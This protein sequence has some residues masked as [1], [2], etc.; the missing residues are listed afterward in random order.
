MLPMSPPAE[1]MESHSY[2]RR[3]SMFVSCLALALVCGVEAQPL[4]SISTEDSLFLRTVQ[5][6]AFEFFW[7]EANASNGLIRDRSTST[8]PSSIASV[9]FGISSLCVAADNGWL[10]RSA[11]ADRV[12][13]TLRTFWTG[14]QGYAASGMIGRLGFF[15]HFLKMDTAVRDWNCELSS[16][17]TGLLLAGV[18]HAQQ[19]FDGADAVETEIRALAD[20]IYRRANFEAFRNFGLWLN[21]GWFP[22]TGW[23]DA[24]WGKGNYSEAMI[25]YIMALGSPTHP[26]APEL[27]TNW[28]SDYDYGTHFGYTYVYYP[29]LFVHQYSHCWIDFRGITDAKMAGY[30]IDYFENSRRATLAQRAYCSANPAGHPGY[31]DS[32]WGITA[33]DGP[34]GIGYQARGAPPAQND[35]GTLAPTAPGGSIVFAPEECLKALKAMYAL[36]CV[37][38]ETRLWGPYGF[39]DAFNLRYN[40]FDLD[41]IGIDEGPIVLMIE[42]FFTQSVWRKFMQS[43]YIQTGLERAGFRPVTSVE[44]SSI[45]PRELWLEQ[46]YPNPFN[47]STTIRYTLPRSD[48]VELCVV[49]LMGRR[50]SLVEA[51]WKSPGAYEVTFEAGELS[52]GTYFAVLRVGAEQHV[53]A[54]VLL[55]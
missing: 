52:A 28:T 14:P 4:I 54:M 15:Y 6:K 41:Y 29:P 44:S 49:D 55:K 2:R 9:G 11:A 19:Y 23:L 1:A 18:L 39:R 25:L 10:A 35:D 30:G 53:R 13:T 50:V 46:N 32:V 42:N 21:M 7:N 37:G 24:W 34:P 38:S 47:P 12:R 3:R 43:P 31:S 26:V 20:S 8:S 45:R 22:E 36:Y 51:A 27:W 33:C 5:R 17:D 48:R 16:I 40:W